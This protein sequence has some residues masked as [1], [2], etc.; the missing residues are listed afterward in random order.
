MRSA[1]PI[2]ERTSR[3]GSE[4]LTKAVTNSITSQG[5]I[6]LSTFRFPIDETMNYGITE[7]SYSAAMNNLSASIQVINIRARNYLRVALL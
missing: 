1:S 6:P 7:G 5:Y 4:F 3:D 2:H